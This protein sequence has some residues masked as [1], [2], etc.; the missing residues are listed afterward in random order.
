MSRRRCYKNKKKEY[1]VQFTTTGTSN[2]IVPAGCNSIDIVEIFSAAGGGAGGD[3]GYIQ[4]H[5]GGAG[6]YVD[7]FRNYSVYPGQVIS[8]TVAEGRTSVSSGNGYNGAK[9]S[10][11]TLTN[12]QEALGGSSA[13]IDGGGSPAVSGQIHNGY[14]GQG[15]AS[16][17][18]AVNNNQY[19]DAIYGKP[20]GNGNYKS[21][22]TGLTYCAGG[23]GGGGYGQDNYT[24]AAGGTC[25]A[26]NGGYG[27]WGGGSNVTGSG[28]GG[29]G[30]R[31]CGGGASGSCGYDYP[32]RIGG[33][34]GDGLIIIKY[35]AY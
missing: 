32:N 8:Y 6:S 17:E 22:I 24:T 35:K 28:K 5:S 1:V 16:A 26:G 2:W 31:T 29:D 10:F 30:E 20:G 9:S 12:T 15:G 18:W 25:D 27:G 14:G 33:K 21:V 19:P 23:G 3:N 34:G 7:V 13:Y 11:G 4:G